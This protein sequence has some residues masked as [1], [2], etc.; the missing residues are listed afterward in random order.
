[1]WIEAASHLNHW[2]LVGDG[3]LLLDHLLGLPG[4]LDVGA[5]GAEAGDLALVQQPGDRVRAETWNYGI[6]FEALRSNSLEYNMSLKTNFKQENSFDQ[7]ITFMN[8]PG[9][10][11]ALIPKPLWTTKAS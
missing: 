1:M 2:E 6:V 3:Q 8:K 11:R 5:L 7:N 4:Q 9:Q 10:Q